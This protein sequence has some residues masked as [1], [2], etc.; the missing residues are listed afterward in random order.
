MCLGGGARDGGATRD[1]SAKFCSASFCHLQ[2]PVA[3]AAKVFKLCAHLQ[4]LVASVRVV[5]F[6][7]SGAA[8]AV[9]YW[10][11]RKWSLGESV[12]RSVLPA[13]WPGR[14]RVTTPKG[15]EKGRGCGMVA[16]TSCKR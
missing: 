4:R 6:A 7:L 1:A 13:G 8:L 15:G 10:P 14:W 2:L 12:T 5:V 11:R 9:A 16:E 3:A